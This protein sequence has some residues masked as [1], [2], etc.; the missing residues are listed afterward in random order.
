VVAHMTR[1]DAHRPGDR[2]AVPPTNAGWGGPWWI[3][4]H[5]DRHRTEKVQA[6]LSCIKE[7]RRTPKGSD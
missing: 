1:R 7:R 4:T 3:V 5:I 2:H 6:M